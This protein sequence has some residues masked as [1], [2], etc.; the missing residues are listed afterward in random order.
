VVSL[1]LDSAQ[2]V[3]AEGDGVGSI[4]E[5]LLGDAPAAQR[6]SDG[7]LAGVWR[8]EA[9]SI[10]FKHGLGKLRPGTVLPLN[11]SP[12][13]GSPPD[14]RGEVDLVLELDGSGG[15]Y[16]IPTRPTPDS[17]GRLLTIAGDLVHQPRA[18]LPI[19]AAVTEGNPMSPQS[20]Q[21]SASNSAP[22]SEAATPDVPVTLTVE[23]GRVNLT[24]S[25]LADLKAGDVIEL[26]RHSRAPIELT[27][28]GRLVARGELILIDTDLGVRVTNVFL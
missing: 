24:L 27:S 26:S 8:A 19:F 3:S 14:P 9:G 20:S 16:R 28:N 11:D 5:L 15:R 17:A 21:P 12:L 2:A 6:V 7:E 4:S 18:R 10:V 25:R 1:W 22:A 13:E 23:L